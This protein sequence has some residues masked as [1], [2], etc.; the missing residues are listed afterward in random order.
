MTKQLLSILIIV[1]A[2][3]FSSCTKSSINTDFLEAARTTLYESGTIEYKNLAMYPNPMGAVDTSIMT[4]SL[5]KFEKSLL[6]Y[7]YVVKW[8]GAFRNQDLVYISTDYKVINHIDRLA[9]F[10][11]AKDSL[12][13]ADDIKNSLPIRMSPVSLLKLNDWTIKGDTIINN[14]AF[15][16][17]LRIENDRINDNGDAILTEQHIYIN[18][19]SKLIER[20]ERRN[21]FNGKLSQLVVYE[22]ADY[23]LR[24]EVVKQEYNYPTNYQTAVLGVDPYQ[25]LLKVGEQAPEFTTQDE[26][27]NLI[28]LTDYRGKKVLLNF[29]I[30]N[31]GHCIDALRHFNQEGYTLSESIAPIYINPIDTQEN[32]K[33]FD[34]KVKIPFPIASNNTAQIAQLY[35]VHSYPLFYLIN[36]EGVIEKVITGFD[37]DFVESLNS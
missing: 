31:C 8:R 1:A 33:A 6:G 15:K 36:E 32:L 9:K 30:I 28:K 17:Y 37:K 22:Y 26:N 25:D 13:E 20:F 2:A 23:V 21:H 4:I 11:P 18:S 7:N 12:K 34:K 35:G 10:Y 5:S 29:S 14:V 3:F 19:S 27:N 24:D 16:N